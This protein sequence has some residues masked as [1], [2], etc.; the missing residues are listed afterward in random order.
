MSSKLERL[1]FSGR[2]DDF[3]YFAEQFEARM[4]SLKLGKV[5]SGEA[6][7]LDYVPAVRNNSSEEQRNQATEKGRE[8][9]EEKKKTLW[10]ELVQALD[11][12]SVLFLSPRKGDGTRAWDVLCKRFKSFERPQLHK[13]IAQLTSLRKTSS[14]SIVNYL[15]R[16]AD[17][18][19]NL[20]LVNEG[21]SEKMFVS[22]ILKGL[23][24]EY[25]NF[26][27]LVKYIKD[28]KT[29]EEIKPDLINFDNENVK[30]KTESVFF[31]KERKCFNCQKM[32]HIA[33]ECRFKKTIPEQTKASQMKCFKC[34]EHGHIAK[35][36]R[37]QQKPEKKFV[38]QSRRTNQ[39]GSQNLVEERNLEE[40]F[41]SFFQ[42]SENNL[43]NELV[44]DSGATSHMIK[45]EIL[46]ID[47]DKE[48][49]G[50]I[51]NANSS[52]SLI[53]GKGTVEIRVPDSNGLERKMRLSNALLVPN[54]TRNLV[55]VSKLRATGNEVV[56]GRTLEIRTKNGTVFPF[57]ERDSLFIWHN[58]D[59]GEQCNLA[60]GDPLSLWHKRLGH[61][62]VEDIYKLKDHA[63]GLKLS[64]HNLTNC[65]TCQLNKSK[66]LPVPKDSGT[67]A[68]EALEIVHT[69]I[70]GPIQPEAVDG[71]RYA[72]G[73]VD[74]FSRYHKLYFLRS[75]DEAFEKVEQFFADIGQPGTL[76]CD[77]AGK[78]VSND[79][80]QLC[81]Q[82]GVR[83]E[84]SAPY[85][86]RK[87]KC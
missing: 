55:S 42:T 68:S 25:E 27:T 86:P 40:D 80:K 53:S 66:K 83:L 87:P 17:M 65:E 60:N 41:F 22:I 61:N 23:P 34:G 59:Y 8:E 35:F 2:E 26:A 48:Y 58:I 43:A 37:K 16:A 74:S 11:K 56:F 20:T 33:K 9:L 21:I 70:L 38:S 54:N 10:Y 28:E 71:H 64:E 7:Y 75:R 15:T 32:G 29:L 50:T 49:S 77:G 46:F 36:C 84:F 67:R 12:T 31:N 73:F 45:D 76:V 14:E 6:T 39:R 69:D 78:Y 62:N 72:I 51:T 18:Q 5:L 79:I 13:L 57:E 3:L 1:E 24:K 44:L 63:A 4:H 30:S 82:K 47:I 81:R 85:T 19:Y 52:K